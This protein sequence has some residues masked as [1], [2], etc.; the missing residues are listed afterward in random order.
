MRQEK[1][2]AKTY[3]SVAQKRQVESCNYAKLFVMNHDQ[4][5]ME[6]LEPKSLAKTTMAKK[7]D[8]AVIA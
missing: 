8:D 4:A 7:K 2:A 5:A 6:E 3:R 1:Y